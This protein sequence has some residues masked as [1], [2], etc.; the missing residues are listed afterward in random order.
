[1]SATAT[2]PS[3]QAEQQAPKEVELITATV[4]MEEPT[5][6]EKA[7]EEQP[8]PV[9]AEKESTLV[10]TATEQRTEQETPEQA[11][12]EELAKEHPTTKQGQVPKSELEVSKHTTA[13]PSTQQ[14]DL[15]DAMA[16]GKAAAEP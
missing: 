3:E 5:V 10:G 7:V 8:M 16:R 15:P 12:I 11:P 6:I 14:G 4:N 9:V 1:M 2:A 13:T